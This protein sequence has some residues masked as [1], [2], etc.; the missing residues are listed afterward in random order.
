[1]EILRDVSI[2]WLSKRWYFYGTSWTLILIGAIAYYVNGG[3]VWGI[4]FSGGTV[5]YLK[6]DKPPDVDLIRQALK[7]D[8][9]G[10]SIIQ[11]FGN[12]DENSV[13]VRMQT[14]LETGAVG[15]DLGQ[16]TVRSLLMNVFDPQDA[17]KSELDFNS[18]G[19][20]ALTAYLRDKD[21][22]N[23]RSQNKT[24]QEVERQYQ[25]LANAL[26]NYRDRDSGGL[27]SSLEDLSRVG[28]V[29]SQVVASVKQ[30]FYA[31]P[32][33]VKGVESVGALVG[34][35]LKRRATLAVGL[36]FLG[37]LVYIGFRYRPIYGVTSI[38]MLFHDVAITL[39][40]LALTRIEI[41]LTV[42]AA[43]L[44][45]VGY[46]VNDTIVIFD[47][48]RENLRIFRKE[49]LTEILNMSINQTLARTVMTSGTTFLSVISLY[50]FGGEV[51]R[52]FSF[53]LTVGIVIGTY[54]TL[55]FAAP[56]VDFWYKYK[57]QK[58]K[59]KAA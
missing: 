41:S 10:S 19:V 3:L 27:V 46:S 38:V 56:I 33:A 59:R 21:P 48:V 11:R 26:L 1:V 8:A 55:G 2:D 31:A 40:L 5:I 57:E 13:Q 44:T 37:M 4:D 30:G 52:G 22:D 51:L 7:P 6:F 14:A 58:P 17:G 23:L 20:D 24:A 49:S 42:I 34:S 35:D 47:R 32:F 25:G 28:G 16:K 45:L 43:L 50:I 9:V 53:V 12:P 54:S 18:V 36:S 39:G 15:T 29:T